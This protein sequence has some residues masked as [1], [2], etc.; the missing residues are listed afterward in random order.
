MNRTTLGLFCLIAIT[1]PSFAQEEATPETKAK[2]PTDS[3][4]Y[5][6]GTVFQGQIVEG[7]KTLIDEPNRYE[8]VMDNGQTVS[9]EDTGQIE[10]IKMDGQILNDPLRHGGRGRLLEMI[11]R[12][13]SQQ[14]A[15][16]KEE[17][18]SRLTAKV[19]WVLGEPFKSETGKE[20]T[21]PLKNGDLVYPGE[22]VRTPSNSRTQC[23]VVGTFT[24]GLEQGAL[25]KIT[26]IDFGETEDDIVMEFAL[27]RGTLWVEREQS[28][29]SQKTIR[30]I[31]SGLVFDFTDG[32][33]RFRSS[34]SG[35]L[36]VTQYD[37]APLVITRNSESQEKLELPRRT[38]AVLSSLMLEG[39]RALKPEIVQVSDPIDWYEFT[40]WKP[41]EIDLPVQFTLTSH[42]RLVARPVRPILGAGSGKGVFQDLQPIVVTGLSQLLSSYRD[43]LLEFY[44][45]MGRFPQPE[46]GL[47]V[48]RSAS[49]EMAD[50][51][52]P[53]LPEEIPDVDPW[54]NPLEYSL[55]KLENQTVVNLYSVG[56]N[57]IDEQ[58][59]GDDL[60]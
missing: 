44:S 47:A 15:E 60:R 46:E 25:L 54:G 5:K 24:I 13:R 59:L 32:L 52:G 50:W 51:K 58:G 26:R 11:D 7:R 8:I 9:I 36:T 49:G 42:D 56:A 18:K 22:E 20:G 55:I 37:G 30:L 43:G 19:G 29:N 35:D 31:S 34:P 27:D 53:Y 10:T 40:T 12:Y 1:I 3:I 16:K 17:E 23:R 2:I 57:G 38:Q 14:S 48:L 39:T 4:I 6:S 33:K 21:T 45:D 41:I 28:L